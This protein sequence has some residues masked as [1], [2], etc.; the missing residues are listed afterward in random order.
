VSCVLPLTQQSLLRYNTV[1]RM[2]E[3]SEAQVAKAL[4]QLG[5]PLEQAARSLWLYLENTCAALGE[6]AEDFRLRF[7]DQTRVKKFPSVVRA[8]EEQGLGPDEVARVDDLIGGRVV[9]VSP[10]DAKVLSDAIADD[11]ACPLE[12]IAIDDVRDSSGYSGIHLKGTLVRSYGAFGCE[13]Q[14]RTALQDAWAV[15]S[16][17]DLYRQK[18]LAEI[19]PKIAQIQAR[20]LAAADDAL[21]L[22]RKEARHPAAPMAQPTAPSSDPTPVIAEAEP[23][24]EGPEE[25]ELIIRNP[26]SQK[27]VDAFLNSLL[28]DRTKAATTEKLF[29]RSNAFHVTS[30]WKESTAS[31]FNILLRKGP[32]VDGSNWAFYRTWEFATALERHLLARLD[33]L[34]DE[35]ADLVGQTTA[36]AEAILQAVENMTEWHSS[37]NLSP[38]LVVISGRLDFDTIVQLGRPVDVRGGLP[39]EIRLPW[40][41][42]AIRDMVVLNIAE[43][44]KP[45]L[46]LVDLA[47]AARLIRYS[48]PIKY[49]LNEYTEEQ[50]RQLIAERPDLVPIPEDRPQSE[51]ERVRQLLLHVCVKLYESYDFERSSTQAVA[52]TALQI[53][54]D[55]DD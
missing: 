50:A 20:A 4:G 39:A 21:E 24:P 9:V 25:D 34:L 14:I 22:I 37:R 53:T 33:R 17:V 36:D 54:S 32:F 35:A 31:G 41:I 28:E 40:V 42:G 2:D 1:S 6:S 10:C 45:G 13:I 7:V 48:P 16:R 19:L 46:Y 18:D 44:T 43:S 5:E 52:R 51:G 12:Q 49:E 27:R 47:A 15:I 38:S 23:M 29:L 3:Q 30:E 11:I 55:P 26:V 8:I